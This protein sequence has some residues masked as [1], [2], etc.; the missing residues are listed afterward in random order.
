MSHQTASFDLIVTGGEPAAG[1]AAIRARQLGLSVLLL[2]GPAVAE[3]PADAGWISAPGSDLCRQCGLEPADFGASE[4]AGLS[5]HSGDLTRRVRVEAD[6]VG[7]CLLMVER[8]R[9]ALLHRAAAQGAQRRDSAAARVSLADGHVQIELAD[10]GR[11]ATGG[12][13]IIADGPGSPVAELARMPAAGRDHTVPHWVHGESPLRKGDRGGDAL[14]IVL[15]FQ[16]GSNL[17]MLTRLDGRLHVGLLVRGGDGSPAEQFARFVAEAD[18]TG[19]LPV[20]PKGPPQSRP[21]P[22]GLALDMHSHVGKRTLLAGEAGG[23]VAAFNND[24]LYPAM[25]SGWL[26]AEAAERALK[27][28]FPQDELG[29]FETAW[30]TELADYLRMPSTDLSLLMPL[31]F[32][33]NLQMSQRVARAFLLG[34]KF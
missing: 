33:E 20:K 12:V 17:A 31:V 21:S 34:E 27:S 22:A 19:I 29:S 9:T 14:S 28:E 11:R 6:G 32:N 30:R 25:R 10:G 1:V 16:H 4:F 13:L 2:D 15:G 7:G 5:L 26:A 3:E 18:R 24:G 8:L 23:F